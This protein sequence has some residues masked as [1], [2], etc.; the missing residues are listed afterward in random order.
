MRYFGSLICLLFFFLNNNNY[1]KNTLNKS[2]SQIVKRMKEIKSVRLEK[3]YFIVFPFT[4]ENIAVH[5]PK[6]TL[7]VGFIV[8]PIPLVPGSIYGRGLGK[9]N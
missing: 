2:L 1:S 7:S 5:M 8:F 6:F 3:V 9:E 4:L